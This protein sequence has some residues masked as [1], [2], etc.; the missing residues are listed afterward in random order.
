MVVSVADAVA[1]LTLE[2]F[3]VEDVNVDVEVFNSGDCPLVLGF[4][5]V[6][7]G[8]ERDKCQP[9]I[10]TFLLQNYFAINLCHSTM[11][12]KRSNFSLNSEDG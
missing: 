2:D 4:L 6:P 5:G 3:S 10:Q 8:R 11:N 9:M 7:A 1:L 12:D